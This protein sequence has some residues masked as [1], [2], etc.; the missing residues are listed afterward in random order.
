[1]TFSSCPAVGLSVG[2]TTLAAVTAERAVTGPPVVMRAGRPIADFVGRV[3]DPIGIVAADGSPHAAAALLAEALGELAGSV[4]PARVVPAAV[5]VAYPAHWAQ[6]SVV[7][8]SRALRRTLPRAR[9]FTLIPDHIAAVSALR[10]DLPARGVVAVCDFG[11][12]AT[13]VTLADLGTVRT[14]GAPQVYPDFSGDLIDRRLLSQVLADAGMTPGSTGTSAIGPLTRLR[15][16]CR[17]AKERLSTRTVTVVPGRPA[18]LRTDIRITRPELEELIG[19]DLAGVPTVVRDLLDRN[20]IAP[21]G[22]SAVVSVGGGAAIPAVTAALSQWLRVPVVTRREPGLAAAVGA[23]LCAR[24]DTAEPTVVTPAAS[25]P[26]PEP[27]PVAW[28]QAADIPDIVRPPRRRKPAAAAPRPRLDFVP[29]SGPAA[30]PVIPWRHRPVVIAAAAL[31]VIAG[32]GGAAAL[33]LGADHAGVSTPP[34][35]APAVAAPPPAEPPADQPRTVVA[36]PAEVPAE[37]PVNDA[38][39]AAPAVPPVPPTIPP[40]AIP[41][42][43][44]L[45]SL[46]PGLPQLFPPPA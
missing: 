39:P 27:A 44:P 5:A 8:L 30:P 34:S 13:T 42:L 14:I 31:A 15:A 10:A 3:G 35:Q 24:Q 6:Q 29:D 4:V 33:A 45:E 2:S 46:I 40:L 1:M 12:S 17:A 41:S 36:V 21:T 32:A 38:A 37:A 26:A 18:G 25:E 16:E 28:S 43:P 22:L 23:V 9:R 7:A 19:E 11:G 20:G